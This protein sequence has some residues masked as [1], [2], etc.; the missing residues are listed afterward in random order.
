[1]KEAFSDQPGAKVW[2]R[3]IDGL[4]DLISM[5]KQLLRFADDPIAF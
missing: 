3:L 5:N 2:S 4:M 1:V